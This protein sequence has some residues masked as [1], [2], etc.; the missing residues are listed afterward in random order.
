MK[1]SR[2]LGRPAAAMALALSMSLVPGHA[3]AQDSAQPPAGPVEAAP[4]NTFITL[5]THGGPVSNAFRSQPA[6]ALLVGNDAY[7]ID[8]GDGAA[9]QL[10]KVNI[11]IGQVKAVFLS[12]LHFD[13][14]GGLGAVLG[15]RLQTRVPGR[16]AIYGPRGTRQL[17]EG[18]VASM[19]PASIVG[20]GI[21]GQG[22]DDPTGTVEVIEVEDGQSYEVGPMTVTVRQNTHYDYAHGSEMDERFQSVSFRYDL[23]DRSIVY[24]GDTGPS[25]A[26]EELAQGADL[27]VS[28]MIDLEA[29]VAAIRRN[30]PNAQAPQILNAIEHLRTH[31]L[32]PADVGRLAQTAG[33]GSLVVTHLASD[34]PTSRDVMRFVD[35]IRESYAGPVVVANDLD[36]F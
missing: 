5:G 24:T 17:V 1:I 25:T 13:H 20:Y 9:Q 23:P 10:A 21:P 33:V 30:S 26:V 3:I 32:T 6:N 8:S 29:T 16:L 31:H 14:T 11:R 7:L 18:L 28:E 4:T 34:N 36:T 15:L 12:H 35:G 22:Y 19:Q 27:L 2:L